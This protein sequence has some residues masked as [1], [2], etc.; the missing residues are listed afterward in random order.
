[1]SVLRTN[2]F[3]SNLRTVSRTRSIDAAVWTNTREA[4]PTEMRVPMPT[5]VFG[6]SSTGATTFA[7]SIPARLPILRK[8]AEHPAGVEAPDVARQLSAYEAEVRDPR[9]SIVADKLPGSLLPEEILPPSSD[10]EQ[11]AFAKSNLDHRATDPLAAE[12]PASSQPH[13]AERIETKPKPGAD[14]PPI[15]LTIDSLPHL[16]L[17]HAIP[18]TVNPLGEKLFTATVEALNLSGTGDTLSDALIVAKEQI[19]LTYHRLIKLTGPDELE[20]YHLQYLKSCI[21]SPDDSP[22]PK[23]GI[24]R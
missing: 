12:V 7:G 4:S 10:P 2:Q 24:W 14:H 16:Q 5:L 17:I 22:K 15:E 13:S 20:E 23:R 19:E 11:Q 3:T 18:V 8:P 6:L 1:V 9:D 21:K